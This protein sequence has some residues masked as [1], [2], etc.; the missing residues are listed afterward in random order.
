M[1]PAWLL[2]ANNSAARVFKFSQVFYSIFNNRRQQI[3]FGERPEDLQSVQAI[4]KRIWEK[5][6][7]YLSRIENF[8]LKKAVYY[9]N[10]QASTGVKSVRGLSEITG[11]DWSHIARVLK[12][13][14]LVEP[15]QKFLN[16]NQQPVILK[17]FNLRCLLEIVRLGDLSSQLAKFKA[18]LIEFE[19]TQ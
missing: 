8:P 4:D 19:L 5:H 18:M 2:C 7:T 3:V 11:V 10:L 13:L 9:R 15:I 1:G 6:Q 14:E 17:L 16:D 12:T